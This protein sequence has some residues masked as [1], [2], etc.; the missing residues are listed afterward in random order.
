MRDREEDGGRGVGGEKDRRNSTVYFMSK[1]NNNCTSAFWTRREVDAFQIHVVRKG[2]AR[3]SRNAEW[4]WE[5]ACA[6][7]RDLVM[8]IKVDNHNLQ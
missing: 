1:K 8:L 5:K 4:V 6:H 7:L 3:C 2:D